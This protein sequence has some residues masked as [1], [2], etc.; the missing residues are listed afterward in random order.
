MRIGKK[1]L[2][3]VLVTIFF[4]FVLGYYAVGYY[5][6]NTLT[7]VQPRCEVAYL[8][9]K[10]D[11]TPQQF[12]SRYRLVDELEEV[13]DYAMGDYETV[14]FPSREDN[15]T[16][17][18]WFIPAPDETEYTVIV[19]HGISSC[20]R[21]STPLIPAGMLH[22]NG[23]NVL[24][25]DMR[26]H[27]DS[28]ITNGRTTVGNREYRDILGAF[29]WLQMQGYQAEHIGLLGISL[30]GGTSVIAFGEETDIPALWVDSPFGNLRDVVTYELQRNGIPTIFV[31][32]TFQIARWNG[33]NIVDLSP[34]TAIQNHN[35][36]AIMVT[37]GSADSRLPL[38]FGYE[39]Y[40]NAGSNADILIFDGFD[41]VEA[42]YH[43]QEEYEEALVDFFT[44]ALVTAYLE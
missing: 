6:F 11:N 27:G 29:D 38:E 21:D 24:M 42:I 35:E 14:N 3:G 18:A 41:H 26:N 9:G 28:E 19:V 32:A 25:I 10:R 16:I 7:V 5:I 31:E 43:A 2:L 15:V 4:V 17:S 1:W 12:F 36:R 8:E 37:H 39:I 22:R 34:E 40:E 13:T 33:L 44:E 30:G 23:F 20:R